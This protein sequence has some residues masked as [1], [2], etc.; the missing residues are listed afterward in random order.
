MAKR[1][2]R[3]PEHP[4][5][6]CPIRSDEITALQALHRG[7]ADAGQQRKVLSWVMNFAAGA[8]M[9]T[10]QPG[11]SHDSIFMLGRRFVAD[12]IILALQRSPE[13]IRALAQHEDQQA[14]ESGQ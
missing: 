1:P 6:R 10:Y 9:P 8:G 14:K 5:H 4:T 13:F 2:D 12:R 11:S 3:I 7:E